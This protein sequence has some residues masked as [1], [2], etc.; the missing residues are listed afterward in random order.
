MFATT[1]AV[2]AFSANLTDNDNDGLPDLWEANF[3]LS[4]NAISGAVGINGALGDPDSDELSNMAEYLTGYT[5]IGQNVYSN[6]TFAVAGLN[7]TNAY[8]ITAGLPDGFCRVSTNKVPLSWMFGDHDMIDTSWEVVTTNGA[9]AVAPDSETDSGGWTLF[10]RCRMALAKKSPTVNLHLTYVG[11]ETIGPVTVVAYSDLSMTYDAKWVVAGV[12]KTHVLGTPDNGA[13]RLNSCYWLAY[14]GSGA[15][16]DAAPIGAATTFSNNW[17]ATDVEIDMPMYSGHLFAYNFPAVV[18]MSGDQRK[19]SRIRVR[20]S[21]VDGMSNYPM[22]LLDKTVYSSGQMVSQLDWL[23]KGLPA[24]DWGL[25]GVPTAMGRTLVGYEVFVGTALVLTNNTLVL[26]FTNRFDSVQAKA[27]PASPINGA[28]VY[29]SRPTFRWRMPEGYTAFALEIRN[30]ST[31]AVIYQSGEQ[32]A[33]ARDQYTG[34]Y[35]WEAPIHA[36]D[37]LPSGVVF[38]P[39]TVYSWHVTAL[40]PKFTL[41]AGACGG[42]PTI[43]SDWKNFVPCNDSVPGVSGSILAAVKYP[44][45]ATNL[46]NRIVVEARTVRGTTGA[47]DA[48]YTLD[49]SQVILATNLAVGATN[50]YLNGL[51]PG[52]YYVVSYIDSNT[53]HLRDTWESWGY[54][55]MRG[56]AGFAS[57]DFRPVTVT[58]SAAPAT[59]SV[60]IEDVD[61]DGDWYPDAWE[62]EK[63]GSTGSDGRLDA[64]GPSPSKINPLLQ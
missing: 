29:A 47:A 37:K 64:Y 1:F 42:D 51:A 41:G 27:S 55:N 34:E 31:G 13:L 6:H 25:S 43:W 58:A 19:V 16:A 22:T 24:L 49:A 61:T 56:T 26:S 32:Q 8:S 36:G 40:N 30:G 33:P 20:R 38:A 12:N 21:V 44:G 62:F 4:T 48:R 15:W 39:N 59:A 14:S 10:E 46:A 57:Y 60:V 5:V 35:V 9:S 54:A 50:I 3:G 63:T 18:Y 53:N 23:E 52:Q 45:A 2:S 17:D 7:P 28:Y 11:P